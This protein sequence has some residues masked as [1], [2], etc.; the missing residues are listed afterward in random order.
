[1][2]HL[3]GITV[4]LQN[5]SLDIMQVHQIVIETIDTYRDERQVVN[6]GFGNIFEASVKL[7]DEV[8]ASVSMPRIAIRQQHRSNPDY[9]SPRDYFRNTIAVPL[10]DHILSSLES[11]FSHALI[12]VSSLQGIV[13]TV[14]C[15]TRKVDLAPAISMY[16]EDPP[17][18]VLFPAEMQR[19]RKKYSVMPDDK[20]P[21]SPAQAIKDC[22][23][24]FFPNMCVL[25]KL[26]CT[27]P[28]TSCECERSASALRRLHNYMRATMGNN[29]LSYLALLY[30]HYDTQS[31]VE[32]AYAVDLFAKMYP[33]RLQLES[34]LKP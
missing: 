21:S 1:M 27:L 30:I 11:Q 9:S 6:R 5:R 34:V 4:K 29:R 32:H 12:V 22:N 10:L 33:H 25:L 19:W 28:F 18:P 13:P 24:V 17:N 8:G 7:G 31:N 3:A 16:E 26:A 15:S 14:M 2:S 23:E 20:R